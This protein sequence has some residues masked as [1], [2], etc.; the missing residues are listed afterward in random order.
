MLNKVTQFFIYSMGALLLASGLALLISQVSQPGLIQP[1]DPVFMIPLPIFFWIVG[2]LE[3]SVGL[4]CL[5]AKNI[6]LQLSA[7]LWMATNF[8]IYWVGM[9]YMG[10][11]GGGY[12]GSIADVFGISYR[13]V[14]TLLRMMVFYVLAGSLFA[15]SCSWWNQRQQ[16]LHPIVK[17]FCPSCGGHI[18][19]ASQNIGQSIP[20][21]HCRKTITLRKPENLKMSCFFCQGHIEFPAHATGGK[22]PCPHCKMD[23]TLKEPT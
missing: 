2:V 11:K 13:Q 17:M 23:I 15:M 12:S 14:N 4:I 18:K 5:F 21:P 22:M 10:V 20:C 3:L 16:R 9:D 7:A 19:F 6:S 1:H 8:I